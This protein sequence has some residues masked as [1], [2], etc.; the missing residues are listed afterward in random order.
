MVIPV[1]H[2]IT[3]D[4]AQLAISDSVIEDGGLWLW[5]LMVAMENGN[6]GHG[7]QRRRQCL[8]EAVMADGKVAAEDY[9]G[10]K[11]EP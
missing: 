1:L 4:K 6:V 9:G 5:H 8:T 10:I 2:G 7:E 3:A 11:Y